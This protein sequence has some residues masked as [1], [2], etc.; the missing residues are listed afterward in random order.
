MKMGKNKIIN[1]IKTKEE[2]AYTSTGIKFWRHPDAMNSYREKSGR[3]IIS[4]H[5]SPEGSC[6]LKCSYCSVSKR[7][8]VNR[9]EL[10]V[11]KN[12]VLALKTRGLKAVILT[13]GGEP[14]LYPYFNEL[15]KWLKKEQG[16]SVALITNG[17]NTHLVEDDVWK[18]FSWV[19]V[20]LNFFEDYQE[21][22]KFPDINGIL[23]ASMV[24]VGQSLEE[25]RQLSEFVD[26]E[27]V[28]YVRV[29]PNC[30]LA[31]EELIKE[32]QKI[33]VML[34]ELEDKRFF[35]QFK[36]H[37]LPC[38]EVCHQA[39]FR[40]YLS[41]VDGGIVFPCDSLVL[42]DE[43]MH[44]NKQYAICTPDEILDFLDYKIEMQFNAKKMC[45][46]CV[47]TENIKLLEQWYNEGIN[48]FEEFKEV[49]VHEE[50]V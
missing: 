17:T 15:V 39:Y 31:Q 13:G 3:T 4:T 32:H 25:M 33:Q 22:I 30:L 28:R 19:R 24:Y 20:S 10:D 49:L 43:Q 12:Y 50:F 23:G 34:D 16:L 35:Q 1:H 8:R 37:G 44:F 26:K 46:G 18:M 6:N 47:F 2:H 27:K 9:I 45:T 36:L 5:I 29:L 21:K 11:V 48:R 41:E 38:S 42:N 7:E 40:P 14:T